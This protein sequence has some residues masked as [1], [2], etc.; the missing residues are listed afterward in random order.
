MIVKFFIFL[1]Q[2]G[3]VL[4]QQKSTANTDECI[5][6]LFLFFNSVRLRILLLFLHTA[7]GSRSY[8]LQYDRALSAY[9]PDPGQDA[10][11]I[12]LPGF[13]VHW[14]WRE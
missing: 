14:R 2:S 1:M 11:H 4:L 13:R 10:V 7:P 9:V 6:R 3:G 5:L 8:V 12:R